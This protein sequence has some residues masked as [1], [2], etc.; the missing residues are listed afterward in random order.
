MTASIDAAVWFGS[1]GT[2]SIAASPEVLKALARVLS[3]GAETV[4]KLPPG[5]PT[6]PYEAAA[7]AI[8]VRV[9]SEPGVTISREADEV[10]VSGH[11]EALR[12]LGR[13]IA[14]QGGDPATVG[15]HLHIEW[16]PEHFYVRAGS[17]PLV[18][19]VA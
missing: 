1:D 17:I 7:H 4:I 13:N 14:S 16:F 9:E 11:P 18:V 19:R 12:I 10:V 2:V 15:S 5:T 8:R 6:P 3:P